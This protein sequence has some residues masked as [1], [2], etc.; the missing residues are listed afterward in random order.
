[1]CEP[2]ESSV[3]FCTKHTK[4]DYLALLLAVDAIVLP[5]GGAAKRQK[6]R[7]NFIAGGKNAMNVVADFG[8]TTAGAKQI[9]KDAD[10]YKTAGDTSMAQ[11]LRAGLRFGAD[12]A[13][14][15]AESV[16]AKKKAE[17]AIKSATVGSRNMGMGSLE[18]LTRTKRMGDKGPFSDCVPQ[19]VGLWCPTTNIDVKTGLL[20]S[21]EE[22]AAGSNCGFN[23]VCPTC[24]HLNTPQESSRNRIGLFT[25]AHEKGKSLPS[26]SSCN[27]ARRKKML[28]VR[29]RFSAL[30]RAIGG[31]KNFEALS[32]ALRLSIFESFGLL[33][34]GDSTQRNICMSMVHGNYTL[35]DFMGSADDFLALSQKT[36]VADST[37]EDELT[38]LSG[39]VEREEDK[40]VAE[41][42]QILG[43]VSVVEDMDPSLAASVLHEQHEQLWKVAVL[44]D[45]EG[46]LPMV[47][48]R[49]VSGHL[50]SAS[51]L[52]ADRFVAELDQV[53]SAG[54]PAG[55]V[56]DR[57]G[58]IKNPTL[59]Q[60]RFSHLTEQTRTVMNF[61]GTGAGKTL[62]AS[63]TAGQVGA[64]EVL[65]VCPKS[66]VGQ[67]VTEFETAYPGQ[68][69]IT[70]RLPNARTVAGAPR[71]WVVNY[72]KFQGDV[73]GLDPAVRYLMNNVDCII[74]DEVHRAKKAQKTSKRRTALEKVIEGAREAKPDLVVI[75]ASAT[76][77]V[78]NLDE[79][80]S[81]LRLVKG[82]DTE[83][84]PTRPTVR[85]SA[86]AHRRLSAA[87]VRNK[88]VHSVN[89]VRRDIT[90]NV[91]G[92]V[93]DI[94]SRLKSLRV[95]S[96]GDQMVPAMMERALLAEKLPALVAECQTGPTV[97]YTH[98]VE[99]MVE[100]IVAALTE[101]GLRVATYIGETND[102]DRAAN[103]SG[104]IA[105]E[106]DVLVGSS[107]IATGVDGLQHACSNLVVAS[108]PWTA[109]DD[110]QL[111]GRLFRH[112]QS[113]NVTVT[114]LLAAAT[115][116]NQN[117]SWCRDHRQARVFFKRSIADAA[118]DGVMPDGALDAGDDAVAK[119][120]AGLDVIAA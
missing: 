35:A 13:A 73:A 88:P 71:V 119:F 61:D 105:G 77:V 60:R 86:L 103:L 45:Q 101:A 91:T 114:Y 87:G 28:G 10:R 43:V 79:A 85:N 25:E 80:L 26:C 92:K 97:V 98:F 94:N 27:P 40:Q 83:G 11:M 1:M 109:A 48:Q 66:V 5:F 95:A 107:P 46:N 108:M 36:F 63:L 38:V 84:F 113:C 120:A 112:G 9:A 89:L 99:G 100:P 24:Q 42:E 57:D 78:N 15:A 29:S 93:A 44:A 3:K 47:R 115:V 50:S 8:S 117:W 23:W 41:V 37:D 116:G 22:M 4:P 68:F 70:K 20:V 55:Y 62:A 30:V 64:R 59:A 12:R 58:I 69:D 39:A 16:K 7:Q 90:V 67:W 17:Y 96:E 19:I 34:G 110:D 65:V 72:D 49:I 14:D 81:L 106:F 51:K 18:P 32:P 76:P 54:L 52:L 21:P 53:T 111:V 74:L 118:V 104:F 102:E 2:F 6:V 82:P 33:G 75:G 31:A 56:T